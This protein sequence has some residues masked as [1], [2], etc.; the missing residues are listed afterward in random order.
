MQPIIIVLIG[1]GLSFL[2]FVIAITM[3]EEIYLESYKII[4]SF[5]L[6]GIIGS[7]F[8]D[9]LDKSR[10]KERIEDQEQEKDRRKA[11]TKQRY[12]EDV[13]NDIVQEFINIFS[14]FYSLRKF[15]HSA[16]SSGNTIFKENEKD[17]QKMRQSCLSEATN[18]EGRF[19]SLKVRIIRHFNL[20]AGDYGT[21]KT[22]ELEEIIES[23]KG[24][25]K[26]LRLRLDA[27]GEGYDKWRHAIEKDQ[28]IEV[29]PAW[30][31]YEILLAFLDETEYTAED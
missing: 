10:E 13:R 24:D 16:H 4:F 27:L 29:D 17:Y 22:S 2:F 8:K 23:K 11:E 15:Y 1:V 5:S 18:L 21:K 14:G 7:I 25:K 30:Q 28:K 6:I 31:N 19:G 9:T 20:P 26:Q 3:E 12:W